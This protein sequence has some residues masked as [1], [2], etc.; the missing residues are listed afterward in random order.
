MTGTSI[1][2][3]SLST[4]SKAVLAKNLTAGQWLAFA[5]SRMNQRIVDT[6]E[7]RDGQVLVHADFGHGGEPAT[8]F[9]EPDEKV[10]VTLA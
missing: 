9:Y 1:P 4:S 3:T 5:N 10:Q 2:P 8:M 7:T 6:G